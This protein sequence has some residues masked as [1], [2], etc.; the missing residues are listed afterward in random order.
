M[1]QFR[2]FLAVF[3]TFWQFLAVAGKAHVHTG[4]PFLKGEFRF[5]VPK[6]LVIWGSEGLGL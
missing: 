4:N 2:Q 5:F 1:S 3:F 6:D